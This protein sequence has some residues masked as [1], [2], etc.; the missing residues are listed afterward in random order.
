MPTRKPGFRDAYLALELYD[1]RREAELRKARDLVG[2]LISA[3]FDDLRPLFDYAHPQNAHLRQV[4][5]YWE[6]AASFVARGLLHPDVYLDT[7]DEGLFTYAVFEEH[8]QRIREIRPGFLGK[9]ESIVAEHPPLK[10][11]LLEIR[12]RLFRSR[13]ARE[14][15]AP[16]GDAPKGDA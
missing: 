10:S 7:C 8:L 2:E 11:R 4:V 9:T 12:A 13:D 14:G 3:S 1:Q 16:E 15:D 5:G 6:L